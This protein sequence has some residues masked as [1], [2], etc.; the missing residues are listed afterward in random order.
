MKE[1][2][3]CILLVFVMCSFAVDA[4]AS[5]L[6]DAERFHI[7]AHG[8][9]SCQDCH[10]D[11]ADKPLHPDPAEVDKTLPDFYRLEQCTTCHED[12][13]EDLKEGRHGGEKI[14]DEL[15]FKY[16]IACH[17]PHYQLSYSNK[18]TKIDLP[19]P[20]EKKCSICHVLYKELPKFSPE[21]ENCLSCHRSVDAKDPKETGYISSLCFHCHGRNTGAQKTDDFP[22]IDESAYSKTVHADIP[23]ITCHLQSVQYQHNHQELGDCR[24]CHLPH[25]EKIAHDTHLRVSCEACHLKNVLPVKDSGSGLIQWQI[26]RRAGRMSAIHSMISSNNDNFCRRCHTNG[27]SIGAVAMLLPAKSVMCMPCHAATFS[28]GDPTTLVAMIIF[29]FGILVAGSIWFSGSPVGL[30]EFG[31]GNMLLKTLRSVLAVIFSGRI[32]FIIKILILDGLFQRRLFRISR[33][34][35][36][37][38]ALIFF[39]I[40]MRFCWGM[41]ALVTSIW[42][43]EWQG[44]WIMLDKNHPLSA[45]LFDL[46]GVLVLLG[47]ALILLRKYV[48]ESEDK[49]KGLPKADWPAYSLM[50]SIFIVGFILEG[51]RIAMT[52]SPEGSQYAFLGYIIS[53]LFVGADLTSTYGYMWYL[54]AILTGAFVACLPFSRMFHMIMAPI[55]LALNAGSQQHRWR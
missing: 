26:D 47:V 38:H 4:E 49:I 3:A 29:G 42:L 27:N 30:A 51:M 34:R 24:L 13:Y 17:D 54:H 15:E 35:W 48:L 14:G 31:V 22:L 32:F 46:S 55:T 10:T 2:L 28:V 25:D 7:S 53:R 36:F 45:F 12:I 50:G 11:I 5:W 8:Q 19:Q 33:S 44:V 39:P 9:N 21:D 40:L 6:I 43:P 52:G 16:C 18:A 20:I 1:I 37:I 41:I 23:C